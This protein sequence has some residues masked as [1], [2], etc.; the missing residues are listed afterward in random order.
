MLSGVDDY[1]ALTRDHPLSL[2]GSRQACQQEA[3]SEDRT[4]N[5]AK[6]TVVARICRRM[7]EF[8]SAELGCK[9]VLSRVILS[10]VFE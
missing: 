1:Q 6:N 4:G 2:P 8:G 7:K 3:K 5:Q 9:L 10:P